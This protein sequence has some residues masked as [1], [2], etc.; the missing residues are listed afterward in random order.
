MNESEF[1]QHLRGLRPSRPSR[2][3][4]SRIAR[5]IVPSAA[6]RSGVVPAEERSWLERLLPGLGWAA[7]GAAAAVTIMLSLNL[8][9]DPSPKTDS[10]SNGTAGTNEP[11]PAEQESDSFSGDVL[12]ASDEGLLDDGDR[13]IARRVRYSSLERRSWTDATGAV[14]VVEVPREDVV[15]FPVAFQ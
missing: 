4:E 6:P 12:D 3:L 15:V 10:P 9:R 11:P 5:E 1:E 8:A 7:V 13:G 2:E 14:T